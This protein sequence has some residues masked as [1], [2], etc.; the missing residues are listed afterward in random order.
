MTSRGNCDKKSLFQTLLLSSALA[1]TAGTTWAQEAADEEEDSAE[2]DRVAVTG[3]R[4]K[5]TDLEGASPVFVLTTEEMEKEGFVTVYD[6]LASL[7]QTTGTI[8][9]ESI[10]NQF[11]A[12]A[13]QLN[14]RGLGPGRTLYLL[15]GR[16]FADYP[17]P[18]NGQSNFVNLSMIP[19]TAIER[20]EVLS[21][22]ASA[23]YGS[24]AVAGVINLIT[25]TRFDGH[26]VSA[27]WGSTKDGG[28]DN[29]LV[30]LAGGFEGNRWTAVYGLEYFDRDPV[31]GKDRDQYDERSDFPGLEQV[32]TRSL[33]Y[34]SDTNGFD[35]DG[36]GFTYEDPGAAACDPYPELEYSLR[37]GRGYYCGRDS[38]GDESL[39]NARERYSLYG[40]FT[41]EV[42][43]TMELF[44]Q[45]LYTD[46]E[47]RSQ[48]FRRWWGSPFPF[49]NTGETGPNGD[50]G[51][52]FLGPDQPAALS[53]FQK[54]YTPA[55]TGE[56]SSLFEED[57]LDLAV[58]L[59]GTF[60]D[61]LW[62]WEGYL[63]YS[64]Y[65]AKNSQ[66]Y[67]KEELVDA[68]YLGTY[69]DAPFGIPRYDVPDDWRERLYNPISP[70]KVAELSGML[71]NPA[72]A[73]NLTAQFNFNG[74]IGNLWG[75]PI[76]VAGVLE[77]ATQDYKIVPDDRLLNTTGQGWW[78]RS[79]T[80][81]GG[82]RDRYAAG[83]E[84]NLPLHDT[85][86]IPL[87]LRYD[88]YDD[89]SDVDGAATYKVG[90]EWRPMRQFLLRGNLGHQLPGTG[91]ALAVRGRLR[92]LHHR[93]GLLPVPS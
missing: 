91:H 19:I 22:G 48:G 17:F 50:A 66:L 65:N 71:D 72:D 1:F 18:F 57:S 58:G 68:Y 5:K 88:H 79:G 54:I 61:T 9:G 20:V 2:L 82:E 83:I 56:Q 60:G 86:S 8:Q 74:E 16:R 12:G 89:A 73:S 32:N 80:G 63:A 90:F 64:E 39:Q 26:E 52:V 49:W 35:W 31:F 13:P 37:P 62:D 59:R 40:N 34:I 85:F 43:D 11:T 51:R 27:R 93:Y 21:G 53:L 77:W 25:K 38:T 84:F 47:T 69:I 4:I 78:G 10:T 30:S 76:G 92:F 81:G 36:D 33:L 75:G 67:F 28:G 15:N 41:F 24:D 7:S 14:L 29:I 23:I 46:G 55:E 42:S 45:A 70:E 44:A 87:A 6:A 3:S